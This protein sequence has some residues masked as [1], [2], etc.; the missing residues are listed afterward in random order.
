MSVMASSNSDLAL[1]AAAS[2]AVFTAGAADPSSASMIASSVVN[3]AKSISSIYDAVGC[4]FG[5]VKSLVSTSFTPILKWQKTVNLPL[6]KRWGH[7]HGL[8]N[9]ILVIRQ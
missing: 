1:A 8:T 6:T 4:E 3:R 5:A 7:G 9:L 2:S